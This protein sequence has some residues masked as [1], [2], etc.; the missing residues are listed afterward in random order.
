MT[1]ATVTA[2]ATTA[3]TA[4][5]PTVRHVRTGGSGRPDPDG[6]VRQ[7]T[8]VGSTPPHW[9][10]SDRRRTDT[11]G[12]YASTGARTGKAEATER[13]DEPKRACMAA[14]AASTSS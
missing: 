5:T 7:P 8:A 4:S 12:G 10:S 1:K 14:T 6:E 3:A 13:A 9:A 11:S 2:M